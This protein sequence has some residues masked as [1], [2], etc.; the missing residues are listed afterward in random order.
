MER[1]LQGKL[2][3]E[4]VENLK[5]VEL[6]FKGWSAG[7]GG[8]QDKGWGPLGGGG[9]GARKWHGMLITSGGGVLLSLSNGRLV[10]GWRL[11]RRSIH[12]D[13]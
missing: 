6:K 9:W 7:E 12:M 11:C 13:G 10:Y 3:V 8:M 4:G 5:G 2:R 1:G